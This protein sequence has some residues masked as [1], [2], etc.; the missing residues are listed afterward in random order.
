MPE[1]KEQ[2][3]FTIQFN[4]ADPVHRQVIDI[5]NQ[6]GRRKAQ[7]I[8]NAV[9]HYLHCPETPDIPQPVPADTRALEDIVRR[10]V[11]EQKKPAPKKQE[12]VKA[13]SSSPQIDNFYDDDSEEQ[14]GK[15]GLTAIAHTIAA[16]RKG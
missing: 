16:F 15:E 8:V 5:L 1:K 6:Q 9:Q 12:P 7:F 3:K 13:R 14:L 2:N 11:E 4:P 10:I